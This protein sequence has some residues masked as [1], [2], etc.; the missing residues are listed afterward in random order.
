MKVAGS[1]SP[2]YPFTLMKVYVISL[3]ISKE[4]NVLNQPH[5]NNTLFNGNCPKAHDGERQVDQWVNIYAQPIA[6]RLNSVAVG[7]SLY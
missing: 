5:F 4:F 2:K 1:M 7:N 6:R 3:S